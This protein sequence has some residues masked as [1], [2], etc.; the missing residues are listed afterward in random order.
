MGHKISEHGISPNDYKVEAVRRFPLPKNQHQLR[1][2]MG[3]TGYFRKFIS[4]FAQKTA[5]LTSLFKNNKKWAWTEK[6]TKIVNLLKE[7]ITSSLVLSIY[8][9][10]KLET[11]LCTDASREGFGGILTQA[12]DKR[13][14]PVVYY[15]KSTI[16]NQKNYH[17]L[18]LE[19]MAI[20]FSALFNWTDFGR[21]VVPKMY[22]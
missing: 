2:F 6:H 3:I 22:R 4:A 15:S 5:E 1:Q 10:N 19:L 9:N 7:G 16:T 17:S 8:D 20:F 21:W 18:E 12:T 13:E 14:K 11:C